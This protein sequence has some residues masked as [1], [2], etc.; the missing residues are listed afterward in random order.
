[1]GINCFY[2]GLKGRHRKYSENPRFEADHVTAVMEKCNKSNCQTFK[3]VHLKDFQKYHFRDAMLV[4][5]L[6][7]HPINNANWMYLLFQNTILIWCHNLW[8]DIL[9]YYKSK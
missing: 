6:D 5:N 2:R 1:M 7:A 3:V 4:W 8:I 9:T